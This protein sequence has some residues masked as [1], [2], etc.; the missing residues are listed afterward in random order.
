[1]IKFIKEIMPGVEVYRLDRKNDNRGFSSYLN[2]GSFFKI[3]FKFIY[4]SNNIH[5]GTFRGFHYQ[6]PFSQNKI[7]YL[8]NG[9]ILDILISLKEKNLS[10]TV[11][12]DSKKNNLLYISKEYAHGYQTLLKNTEVFYFIDKKFNIKTS[13]VIKL[14]NTVY[15]KKLPLKISKISQNDS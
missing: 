15:N 10:K 8:H 9:K 7:L 1:M 6:S 11:V 14:K 13:K 4:F 2:L 5:K 12:L 3:N